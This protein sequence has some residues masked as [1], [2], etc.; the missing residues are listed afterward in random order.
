MCPIIVGFVDS[1]GKRYEKKGPFISLVKVALKFKSQPKI[2]IL[3][4]H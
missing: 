4:G 3:K 2:Q 1:F